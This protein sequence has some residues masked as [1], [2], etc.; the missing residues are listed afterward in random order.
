MFKVLEWFTVLTGNSS[1]KPLVLKCFLSLIFSCIGESCSDRRR[2]AS[3]E[4]PATRDQ[5]PGPF[6]KG[7]NINICGFLHLTWCCRNIITI[8]GEE[9]LKSIPI[10]FLTVLEVRSLKSGFPQGWAPFRSSKGGS[11]L[12]LPAPG[13][14][15][16]ICGLEVASLQSLPPSSRG[17]LHV[18]VSFLSL[19]RTGPSSPRMT[20]SYL[21]YICQDPVSKKGLIYRSWGWGCGHI[22]SLSHCSIPH[23]AR[24]AMN[25]SPWRLTVFNQGCGLFYTDPRTSHARRERTPFPQRWSTCVPVV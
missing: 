5:L 6:Y 16:G 9:E 21:D 17:L 14:P 20:S 7:E 15:P 22:V 1:V 3:F 11:V 24:T 10:Y 4:T 19:T 25:V 2:W 23:K 13:G 12:P 8:W 18:S